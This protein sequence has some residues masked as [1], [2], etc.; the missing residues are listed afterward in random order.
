MRQ[1]EKEYA[2]RAATIA[3]L[4]ISMPKE[5]LRI[6]KELAP[7]RKGYGQFLARLLFEERARREARQEAQQQL[8]HQMLE[9]I[10]AE[11]LQDGG[12]SK[13]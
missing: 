4:N 8:R 7:T 1:L 13:G 3:P 2:G 10:E 5:A 12:D 9:A 11:D 6:L